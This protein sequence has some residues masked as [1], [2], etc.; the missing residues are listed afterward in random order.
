MNTITAKYGHTSKKT[1]RNGRRIGIICSRGGAC[2]SRGT[3]RRG[4]T[5]PDI[6]RRGGACPSRGLG[7]GTTGG[8]SPS[9]TTEPQDTAQ[10]QREGQAP[11]LRR[12][13]RFRHSPDICVGRRVRAGCR[14]RQPLR[15]KTCPPACR[16]RRP[17]RAPQERWSCTVGEGLA[18]P[19]EHGA[20]TTGGAS[21]SPT[22]EPAFSGGASPS[23]TTESAFSGG[24]SPSPTTES[25]LP[26]AQ[27]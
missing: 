27:P 21:P 14:G 10:G 25:A 2:P 20:R 22:T 9:P 12:N 7:A 18:P 8:A 17:R 4:C 1:L 16:G 26:C 11:P 13:R 6:T 5:M 24:A 15:A 19:V 3:R 23:P